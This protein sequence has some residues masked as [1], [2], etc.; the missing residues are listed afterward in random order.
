MLSRESVEMKNVFLPE[1]NK[2]PG[3]CYA[4]TT[5]GVELPVVDVSHP[6]FQLAVTDSEQ[7]KLIENF[8]SEGRPLGS[9]PR[10]LRNL[11]L[12][13]FLRGSILARGIRQAQGTFM[14]GMNT[15]LLKLGPE[16][17]GGAYAKPID[18]RI[19]AALPALAFL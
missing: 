12:R 9:L 3:I 1:Q 18:R 15:Y 2:K 10:P 8:L 14:S 13:F 4:A 16:M 7:R 11:V 17:L 5:D 6:A 19:A